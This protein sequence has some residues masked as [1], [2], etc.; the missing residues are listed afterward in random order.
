MAVRAMDFTALPAVNFLSFFLRG[1]SHDLI[2]KDTR[3][4]GTDSSLFLSVPLSRVQIHELLRASFVS[5]V[6]HKLSSRP[7]WLIID[8]EWK[9][10]IFTTRR[11]PRSLTC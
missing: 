4:A 7:L 1:I 11:K 10:A 2:T 6:V 9:N 5:P 3:I 8:G